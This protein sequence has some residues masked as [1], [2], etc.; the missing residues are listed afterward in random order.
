MKWKCNQVV[1]PKIGDTRNR[2]RFAWLPTRINESTIVWLE[3]F[4]ETQILGPAY[5]G[6]ECVGVMWSSVWRGLLDKK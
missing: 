3:R 2:V 1:Y 6:E 4:I 5:I